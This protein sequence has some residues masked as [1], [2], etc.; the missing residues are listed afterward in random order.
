[1]T[2]K[3]ALRKEPRTNLF[4]T[5]LDAMNDGA[6]VVDD[7]MRVVITNRALRETLLLPP[8]KQ[9]TPLQQLLPEAALHKAFQEVL[10]GDSARQVEL[11]HRGLQDRIFDVLVAP[12]PDHEYWGHRALGVFHD[13]TERKALDRMLR[14]FIANASHELRTPTAAILG[15]AETLAEAP[16][17]DPAKFRKF[18][19]TLYRH[20]QRLH[21]LLEELLDLSR[22]DAQTYT[23]HLE[24]LVVAPLLLDAL[25][26]QRQPAQDA[27]LSVKWTQPPD[28]LQVLA[29][30]GA[31]EVVIGN[32][33]QNAVK[34]TPAGGRIE[35]RARVQEVEWVRI[36]I[37]D[38]GIGISAS[39]QLRVFERFYRVDKGR[40][41]RMGGVGL[42]LSIVKQLVDTLGGRIELAS[43]VGKGSTFAV[44]LPRVK[45]AKLSAS[46]KTVL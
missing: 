31:L 18:A 15:Y 2:E 29:D 11:V 20:A 33:V 28:S 42:G 6:M 36:E 45:K 34:Y 46:T 9:G 1:M 40:S 38:S 7:K 3:S 23:L 22:L 37:I 43:T 14:D 30:R 10:A 27:G 8:L 39:D 16:P 32:L 24:P 19:D 21:K 25:E 4:S 41:R 5:V 35:V 26:V 12:L 17:K 13:V 44:I